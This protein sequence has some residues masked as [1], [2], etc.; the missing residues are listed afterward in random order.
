MSRKC[1]I[2][3]ATLVNGAL[4]RFTNVHQGI[5]IRL[6]L[7]KDNNVPSLCAQFASALCHGPYL[8]GFDVFYSVGDQRWS[9]SDKEDLPDG[10]EEAAP[11]APFRTRYRRML[12]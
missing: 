12:V 11:S 5:E 1:G 4:S 10:V 9:L 3:N 6:A 7:A 8:R 2:A